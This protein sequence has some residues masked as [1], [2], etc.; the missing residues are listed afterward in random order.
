[1]NLRKSPLRRTAAVAAGALIGLAGVA[2]F[3]APASAH[4]PIIKGDAICVNED[5]T[6]E[7]TWKVANS[8]SDIEAKVTAVAPTPAESSISGIAVDATLPRLGQG[9]L[10][11]VQKLPASADSAD[12]SVTTEWQRDKT[13]T[14]TRTAEHPVPKPTEKC[15]STPGTPSDEPSTPSDEPSTPSDE[16]STPSDEPSTP[17]DEPSTPSEES[18]KPP[19]PTAE[20]E[21]VY[22]QDCDTLTVGITIPADWP[23]DIEVTFKPSVGK[24]KVVFG[25]RGQTVTVD[26]PASKGLKVT[27]YPKGYDE[28]AATIAYKAPADCD[29]AG[30][31]GGDSDEPSLPLTGAAAGS[32]AAGAGV[33]LAAGVVLFFV[34][35]RRKV[36]FTA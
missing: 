21:F 10:E 3:A 35:R 34:A 13:I 6:W 14:A 17:S 31:G 30:G 33:L 26:F 32:I 19:A 29:T 2:A 12:I 15:A 1:M 5:G 24:D 9:F 28:E 25:K 18:S 7:V 16:P 11:G 8:E 23:E 4:H 22:D 27:A 36:K 20:P